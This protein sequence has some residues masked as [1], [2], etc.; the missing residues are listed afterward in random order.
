MTDEITK[1][2]LSN[3]SDSDSWNSYS[4]RWQNNKFKLIIK[5]HLINCE[6]H[7][8]WSSESDTICLEKVEEEG[9]IL[10]WKN[11]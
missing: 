7:K 5:G 3:Q 6:Y 2:Q 8:K 11:T 4:G 1:W 9:K 10:Q